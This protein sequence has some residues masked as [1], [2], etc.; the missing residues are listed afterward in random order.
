MGLSLDSIWGSI[1]KNI[2]EIWSAGPFGGAGQPG[3]HGQQLSPLPKDIDELYGTQGTFLTGPAN[4]QAEGGESF[5]ANG[6][7]YISTAGYKSQYTTG[8]VI[9][10]PLNN[11]RNEAGIKSSE[12]Q[13]SLLAAVGEVWDPLNH[14]YESR[15]LEVNVKEVT[16]RLNTALEE[17]SYIDF[18]FPNP[19]VG[20]RRVV[21]FENPDINE[22]R[23]PRY[24]SKN[25]VQRNEPV[26]LFVGSDARKVNVNFSYTLPHAAEFFGKMSSEPIGFSGLPY[27]SYFTSALNNLLGTSFKVTPGA[28]DV[29]V[30]NSINEV[31]PQFTDVS[32]F[33]VNS[34][35]DKLLLMSSW[36]RPDQKGPLAAATSVGPGMWMAIYYAQFMIDTIRASVLGDQIEGGAPNPCRPNSGTGPAAFGPPIVRIRHG[37]MYNEEPYIV[38]NYQL[39][40]PMNNAGVDPRTLLPRQ[41]FVQLQLEEFRQT[42]GAAHGVENEGVLK[43][44]DVVDL[45]SMDRQRTI[46]R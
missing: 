36:A 33:K 46:V 34:A 9:E 37:T 41:M 26:R 5:D 12:G 14:K 4:K 2:S 32:G 44:S 42:F 13:F 27:Q 39:D 15:G 23:A 30:S 43:A 10:S 38:K 21:F 28:G 7:T 16:D 45:E 19:A 18:Y 22:S 20:T 8:Q 31:G 17:R 3:Y 40:F 6:S 11:N 35:A 25:I 29:M 1:T 24:S